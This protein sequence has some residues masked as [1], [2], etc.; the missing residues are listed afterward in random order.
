MRWWSSN[1]GQGLLQPYT[2]SL[3]VMYLFPASS[4]SLVSN[5]S[6]AR[7]HLPTWTSPISVPA[8]PAS[9]RG[10]LPTWAFPVSIPAFLTPRLSS[11]AVSPQPLLCV[12]LS[13][14]PPPSFSQSL[15]QG[16]PKLFLHRLYWF[17][18]Q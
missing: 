14:S 2:I 15:L 18:K 12:N 17:D 1:L 11:P 3:I 7:G 8:Y 10:P 6:P 9:T 4:T 5:F 16:W 13:P